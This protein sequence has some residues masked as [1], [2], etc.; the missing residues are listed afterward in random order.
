MSKMNTDQLKKILHTHANIYVYSS[1]DKFKREFGT[2][3]EVEAIEP[4]LY[5]GVPTAEDVQSDVV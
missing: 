5:D 2:I 4:M 3:R 1:F